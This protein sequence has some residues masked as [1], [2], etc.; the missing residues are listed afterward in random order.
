MLRP[1]PTEKRERNAAASQQRLLDA[2]EQEFAS[3]GFH[4]ARLRDIADGAGVQP[5]LIHHYFADKEGLYRAVVE[6]A[7]LTTSTAS[8]SILASGRDLEG[9]VVA[10]V[11]LL[12]E[13][14]AQHEHLLA[15][16][17]HEAASGGGLLGDVFRERTK[18][19]VDAVASFVEER[20]GL[21]EVRDDVDA[22]EIILAAM[23][24]V[25]YPFAEADL[26]VS[27]IPTPGPRDA[28]GLAK[29]KRSIVTLLLRGLL[30]GRS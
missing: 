22:R 30:P 14:Y 17:R 3:R 9:L 19:I 11:D 4:G 6:R 27:C 29:R 7:L 15:I 12:V 20:Q 1:R 8:W 23:S 28:A 2:A 13:F 5:A 16:L 25:A 26:L 10:F 24:M 18:P 21:G